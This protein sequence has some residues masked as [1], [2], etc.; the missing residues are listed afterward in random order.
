[1][2]EEINKDTLASILKIIKSEEF[3]SP[4]K[5]QLNLFLQ[6]A[7]QNKCTGYIDDLARS[8]H[9]GDVFFT[10]SRTSL[11]ID[12]EEG[13][14]F[15][16]FLNQVYST[17][18]NAHD[19]PSA[20]FSLQ[21]ASSTLLIF[22][23]GRAVRS[24]W[25]RNVN[26]N[27]IEGTINL[28]PLPFGNEYDLS[29]LTFTWIEWNR[30]FTSRPQRIVSLVSSLFGASID[31][32]YLASIATELANQCLRKS[33]VHFSQYAADVYRCSL[34]LSTKNNVDDDSVAT[35]FMNSL[36]DDLNVVLAKSWGYSMTRESSRPWNEGTFEPSRLYLR[37]N[38]VFEFNEYVRSYRLIARP[39]SRISSHDLVEYIVDGGNVFLIHDPSKKVYR[40]DLLKFR[41][42][43][44]PANNFLERHPYPCN[45]WTPVSC[46]NTRRLLERK[47]KSVIDNVFVDGEHV[48][49][50]TT[51]I[52]YPNQW[53]VSWKK[54]FFQEAL[55]YTVS[56]PLKQYCPN[57]YAILNGSLL[58]IVGASRQ[59]QSFVD[60][61]YVLDLISRQFVIKPNVIRRPVNVSQN[62]D[63]KSTEFAWSSG[64]P[65]V[66]K[67]IS[68]PLCI[69]EFIVP[70]SREGFWVC[71]DR[72][73][74][75]V[76][77]IDGLN[78]RKK[79]TFCSMPY[80]RQK[81]NSLDDDP[82]GNT[83]AALR[84]IKSFDGK[85][86]IEMDGHVE[87]VTEHFESLH[88]H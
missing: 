19:L 79:G 65:V 24:S 72:D 2:T 60:A 55:Q 63:R 35:P 66:L 12:Q 39:P 33:S 31:E 84:A 28:R 58:T 17:H 48:V 10:N 64:I 34:R 37:D 88:M 21:R 51:D 75:P 73:R 29:L 15:C 4:P 14:L 50:I 42:P 78:W 45:E 18:Y 44:T 83:V 46:E 3:V 70:S 32:N 8:I 25:F 9:D 71:D 40:L 5:S 36:L 86:S 87:Y 59:E 30:P 56:S 41:A 47:T 23:S 54:A 53:R 85:N 67:N 22:I 68:V 16:S 1:M 38:M 57:V 6:I 43:D 11:N 26:Y 52:K 76:E 74:T 80:S 20:E 13:D 49:T 69:G 62:L 61:E 27:A 81:T 7:R 82:E 77:K